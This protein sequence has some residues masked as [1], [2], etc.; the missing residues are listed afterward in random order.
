MVFFIFS[1]IYT[2]TNFMNNFRTGSIASNIIAPSIGV[3]MFSAFFIM[4]SYNSFLKYRKREFGLFM[5]LGMTYSYIIKMLVIE[6]CTI[7]VLSLLLG[8]I[9]GTLLSPIFYYL[10]NNLVKL[11]NIS[12]KLSVKSYIYSIAFFLII[13][14][15]MLMINVVSCKRYK[16]VS[17]L[18]QY[19]ISD[20]NI[21]SYPLWGIIG[22]IMIFFSFFDMLY[23]YNIGNSVVLAR[24]FIVSLIGVYLCISNII[25]FISIILKCSKKLRYKSMLIISNLQHTLGQTKKILFIIT[26]LTSITIFFTT[27]SVIIMSQS[28]RVAIA[29][30]PYDIAYIDLKTTNNIPDKM[31][32][33]SIH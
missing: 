10:I 8:L 25:F 13:F 31:L 7:I 20:N 16:I 30:N 3:S 27:I 1:T 21:L 33:N 5:I 32:N 29:Y 19:R 6:T 15:L 18:K 12:F 14:I 9:S 17:L 23:N 4:Y 2:N 11:N 24:S 26:L 22:A 28:Q